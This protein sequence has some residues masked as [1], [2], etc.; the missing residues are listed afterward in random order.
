MI[1]SVLFYGCVVWMKDK[2]ME[3]INHLWYRISKKAVGPIFNVSASV[4][5]IILGVPPLHVLSSIYTTKH[6]LK[7]VTVDSG[8]LNYTEF[9]CQEVRNGNSA[10]LGHI[11]EAYSFLRWKM[12]CVPLQFTESDRNIVLTRD[13]SKFN[14]LS[15]DACLYTKDLTR[16]Y[17]EQLWQQSLKIAISCW[18]SPGHLLYQAVQFHCLSEQADRR[19]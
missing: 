14:L 3:T 1:F 15:K 4:L 16:R 13:Y 10:V 19:R 2:N 18:G 11:K 12:D 5:E 7:I 6:Y 9:V 17:T 8:S